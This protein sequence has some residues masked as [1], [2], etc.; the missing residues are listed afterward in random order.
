MAK[1][2]ITGDD[3]KTY[4]VKVKKPFYKRI[5]FWI[6]AIIVVFIAIGS[7]GGGSDSSDKSSS[8]SSSKASSSST[9]SSSSKSKIPA[10]YKA[11]L[12]KAETYATT[13]DMSEKGVYEQLISKSGEDFEPAAAKYAMSH[14]TG[15]DWNANALA[16]AKTYQKEM[17]MSKNAVY[18]QLVSDSGEKFTASQAKFAVSQLK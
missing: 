7:M 8:N 13:M 1:K 5:W 11:A 14:L 12:D 4:E 18:D 10:E 17:D 9:A 16:K 3:G 15:A 6:L 2:T